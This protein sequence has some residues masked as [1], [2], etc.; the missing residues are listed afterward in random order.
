MGDAGWV[1]QFKISGNVTNLTDTK[2]ISTAVVTGAS[3]GFQGFPI[4]PRMFFATLSAQL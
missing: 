3:G 1:K 2:G 4:P